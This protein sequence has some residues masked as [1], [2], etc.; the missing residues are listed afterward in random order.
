MDKFIIEGGI[1]LKGAVALSGSKNAALP[2][3]AATLL[4]DSKCVIKNVPPLRDVYTM[5]RILR[6]LGVKVNMEDDVVTIEPKG[7]KNYKA[8]YKLVSTMRASV[9]VLGPILAK[10]K[11][12][13]VSMP[14]GCVIG[15]RPIDLH[16]KGLRS[17]GADIKIDHGYIVAEV[18]KELRGTRVYLG[19]NFGSSVLATANIMMAA[20]LAKGKTRI[21][22]AAC[23]PEIHDLANFLIK[24]GAKIKGHGTP[25]IEITGVSSL[26]GAEHTVIHDRIEAGTL[27]IA[28]A[29][30][31]GDITIKHAKEEHVGAIIDKL[32]LIGIKITKV[33]DG[34]RVQKTHSLK[35][36]DATTLPYPGFPTDMQAQ[37]TALMSITKGISI[38]TE[39]IYPKRFMH[40]SEL[41]RMGAYI[42][43]EGPTA[44]VNGVTRL[45][46]APVMA[47]DLRA[48]AALILAGLVAKGKTEISRIYH[49]D[50]GYH[51]L[52]EKLEKLGAKIKRE[53]ED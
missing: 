18:K 38:I 48:S 21:E 50:R 27:M 1:K 5:L 45:S 39:K 6:F 28:A 4:T 33:K 11:H 37:M 40:V 20:T 3:L 17:I 32:E 34:L 29:I 9:C 44:I 16:I 30:T 43:L 36:I 42:N 24:M 15:P 8:P 46:G 51:N 35:P 2:I 12:A 31:G 13:E 53:K 19:G 52:E 22:S 26:H 23:E 49:L 47:S 41:A 14:G 7:Y 25:I 10:L